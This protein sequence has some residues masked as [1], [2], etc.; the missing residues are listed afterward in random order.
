MQNRDVID[1]RAFGFASL[2]AVLAATEQVNA[3]SVIRISG[4]E[5]SI[6][7]AN[8]SKALLQADDFVL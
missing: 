3:D 2:E 5:A 4:S 7:I 6:T 8:V 1:L